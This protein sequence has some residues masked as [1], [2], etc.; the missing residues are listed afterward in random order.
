MDIDP[1][2]PWG[3][4]IDYYGRAAVTESG[5][6]VQIR[7]Y[8]QTSGDPLA[9]DPF[10][11]LYPTVYV[12]AQIHESGDGDSRLFGIGDVLVAPTGPGPVVPNQTAVPD[13]VA[14]AVADFNSRT[15]N[16]AALCATWAPAPPPDGATQPA[17]TGPATTGPATTGGTEPS[18]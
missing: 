12:T 4:A 10:T 2:Q 5:L 18:A 11:G 8:D 17:A 6:T 15:A 14:A 3:I 16:Y 9:P 7:V 13:A 1:S